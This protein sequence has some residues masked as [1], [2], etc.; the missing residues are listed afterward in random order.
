MHFGK[1]RLPRFKAV[2]V[3]KIKAGRKF[4]GAVMEMHLLAVTQ[5][6]RRGLEAG[7]FHYPALRFTHGTHMGDNIA[8]ADILHGKPV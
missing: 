3:V 6:S 7:Q 4:A 5:G 8:T 2:A 1:G